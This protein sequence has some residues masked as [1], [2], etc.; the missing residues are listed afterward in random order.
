M[1][2]P[3]YTFIATVNA[4]MLHHALPVWVDVDPATAQIDPALVPAR[5]N[6]NTRCVIP[7][8]IGGACCDMDALLAVAREKNLLVLEDSCQTH[9]GEWKGKR[10]GTLGDAGCYSFQN[11]KNITA[12]EGG[13]MVT[14][15][16]EIYRR[17]NAFQNQGTGKFPSDGRI[18]ANGGNFRM[19]PFQ[20]ALLQQQLKRLD[21]QS[22]RRE[23]NADYLSGMLNDI[24]GVQA[25]KKAPGLT[26]HGYHLYIFEFD[27]DQFAGMNKG[28][29]TKALA[30]EGV[31]VSGGYTALNKAAWVDQMLNQRG[32]QRIYGDK[33][34][35]QWRDENVLPANDKMLENTC[36]LGQNVL[37]ADRADVHRIGE[38]VKR[39]KE[40]AGRIAKA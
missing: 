13:A 24:G 17:A 3:P 21:E 9:T 40:N 14:N 38:A 37:L 31:P 29:F 33:R 23:A 1:L 27:P 30:A 5:V 34:L 32:F 11:S 36:W 7:V 25:K 4:V 10:L 35:K 19:P 12:G 22:R 18:T 26:R 2:V 28:T 8:H 16:E 15:R 6:A 20:G 39:I